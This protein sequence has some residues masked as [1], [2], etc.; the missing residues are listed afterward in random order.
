MKSPRPQLTVSYK[1]RAISLSLI[2]VLF[3]SSVLFARAPTPSYSAQH[4]VFSRDGSQLIYVNSLAKEIV[5]IQTKTGRIIKRIPFKLA[6]GSTLLAPT[7]DG[8]KLLSVHSKGIDV[9]HNGTGKVLRTLPHP[10]GRYDWRGMVTQ[11]NYDGS[12]LAIPSIRNTNPKIYLIHTGTGKII[13]QIKL[14]Q[15]GKIDSI[16]F[17]DNKRLLAYT[18]YSKDGRKIYLYDI[19]QQKQ[20]MSLNIKYSGNTYREMIHFNQNNKKL[21]ISGIN[22]TA[23]QLIDIDK[24]TVTT[25]NYPYSSFTNFSADNKNLVIV[26]PHR[27]TITMRNLTTGK[28]QINRLSTSKSDY[29]PVI[30]QS[31]SKAV[32]A[33]PKRSLKRKETDSFLWINAQTG[34]VFH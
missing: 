4:S 15:R 12:L 8:F 13:R 30:I 27:N 28:Q 6:N 20:R 10:S 25:L 23:I 22:Q 33:L 17:S 14:S 32:L 24:Q 3:I 11:Q 31:S 29:F 7:P 21:L 16:R 18:Q 19:N 26:Q 1:K 34:K 2:L 5:K 9:I